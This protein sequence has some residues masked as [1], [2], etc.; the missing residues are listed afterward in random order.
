M[1]LNFLE[2]IPSD[3]SGSAVSNDSSDIA[4]TDTNFSEEGTDADNNADMPAEPVEPIMEGESGGD[5]GSALP[6]SPDSTIP[7]EEILKQE[8]AVFERRFNQCRQCWW[9]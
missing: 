7:E 4:L 3:I 1:S 8:E 5:A 6:E 2:D 9:K